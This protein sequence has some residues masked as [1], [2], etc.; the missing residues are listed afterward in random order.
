MRYG[1]V[2]ADVH[3]GDVGGCPGDGNRLTGAVAFA[4]SGCGNRQGAVFT[5]QGNLVVLNGAIL[6]GNG[7]HHHVAIGKG[8]G[9][10]AGRVNGCA[11]EGYSKSSLC[12]GCRSSNTYKSREICY[13]QRCS[14]VGGRIGH[15]YARKR[16]HILSAQC[17][18]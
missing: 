4:A 14:R 12:I 13:M 8:L 5:A 2:H 9:G 18:G 6:C 15:Y 10:V 3:A 7:G 11:V 1:V 17:E 16:Q